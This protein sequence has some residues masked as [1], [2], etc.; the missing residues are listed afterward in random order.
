MKTIIV[1]DELWAL[2]QLQSELKQEADVCI[3]G[4]F[5]NSEDALAYAGTHAVDFAL[6][7]VRMHGMN[8]LMLGRALRELHPQVII[9][10]VSSYP[11]YFSEAY[12]NVRADYYMLKPYCAD[13]VRDVLERARLLSKRQKKRVQVRTFGRFDLFVDEQPVR[14]SNAK[15]KEL[16]AICVD[17]KGGIVTMEE[18]IDKLWEDSLLTV[19]VKAKYRKAVSYLHTLFAQYQI[20]DIFVSGYANCHV[21]K[22]DIS[23]DYYDFLEAE[24]KPKYFGSYMYEYSW[25]EET[26]AWLDMQLQKNKLL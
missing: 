6:L 26:N 15:A 25:A 7:D 24:K 14:F 18:A 11:E 5:Q 10:Y 4:C 1:D 2:E 9:V 19:N 8:G 16:F 22:E 21:V 12:R 20:S 3:C 23:C 17:R 13:D